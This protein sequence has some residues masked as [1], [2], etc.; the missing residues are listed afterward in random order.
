MRKCLLIIDV[1]KGFINEFTCHIPL[2]VENLQVDYDIVFITKFYNENN[3]FYRSLIGW[4]KFDKN[5]ID[6]ELAF[7]PIENAI[8]I[9]KN[10][11][12]CVNENFIKIINEK[13]IN[14][15]DLVGIDTDICV[16]KCAIDLFEIGIIPRVLISYCAS[17]A[18]LEL[19]NDSIKNLERFIGKNQV[20]LSR[21]GEIK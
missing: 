18:G 6:F 11:Y 21:N 10:I 19:H 8:I 2:L 14:S 16:T 13:N 7:N 3:S 20:I 17:H 12:S 5:S 4:D 1:Q 15:I 9:E